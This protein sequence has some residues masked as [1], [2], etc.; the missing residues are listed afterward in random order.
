MLPGTDRVVVVGLTMVSV[1]IEVLPATLEVSVL[2]EVLPATFDVLVS[3]FVVDFVTVL[4][5][6]Q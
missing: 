5:L 3:V 2:T 1:L 4:S 6:S